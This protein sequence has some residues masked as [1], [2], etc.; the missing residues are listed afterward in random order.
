MKTKSKTKPASTR[1]PRSRAKTVAPVLTREGLLTAIGVVL[2]HVDT[3]MTTKRQSGYGGTMNWS[4]GWNTPLGEARTKL[5][6]LTQQ[7]DELE[8][9]E[10]LD[11]DTKPGADDLIRERF[12][13]APGEPLKWSRPGSFLG[14]IGDIP[15]RCNW[16]G[17][18]LKEEG[19]LFALDARRLFVEAGGHYQTQVY[20]V[21]TEVRSPERMMKGYM[22]G[23][24]KPR[25][26]S[27]LDA[28]MVPLNAEGR[29]AVEAFRT[30]PANAWWLEA[31]GRGPF[32]SVSIPLNMKPFQTT[33]FA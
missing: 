9:G 14:W 25:P 20:S 4:Y 33:L 24:L 27:P 12:T 11:D 21:P 8:R 30:D 23:A 6:H 31:I 15:V 19:A 1:A 16:G 5:E 3:L 7:L 18:A 13:I 26:H 29:A 17:F 2:D 28:V 10:E 22:I 32:D